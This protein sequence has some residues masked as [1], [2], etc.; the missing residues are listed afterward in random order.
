MVLKHASSNGGKQ[1]YL[2]WCPVAACCS[3]IENACDTRDWVV[4]E[5]VPLQYPTGAAEPEPDTDPIWI[6]FVIR[7]R[8]AGGLVPLLSARDYP[9]MTTATSMADSRNGDESVRLAPSPR[10]SSERR[11]GEQRQPGLG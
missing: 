3:I 4:Q 2:G 9:G 11:L 10:T 5:Y 1:V 6:A 7:G 8:Y